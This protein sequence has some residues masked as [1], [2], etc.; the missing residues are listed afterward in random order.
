MHNVLESRRC[1]DVY[2]IINIAWQ[3]ITRLTVTISY[4][5]IF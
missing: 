5:I 4:V 3:Y 2:L 1:T